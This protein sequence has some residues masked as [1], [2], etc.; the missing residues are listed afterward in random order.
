MLS[1][2]L[3]YLAHQ[4]AWSGSRIVRDTAWCCKL[5]Q[6]SGPG[7]QALTAINTIEDDGVSVAIWSELSMVTTSHHLLGPVI[8]LMKMWNFTVG[9]ATV[10]KLDKWD[11]CWNKCGSLVTVHELECFCLNILTT[12]WFPKPIIDHFW[13]VYFL[14]FGSLMLLLGRGYHVTYFSCL[15]SLKVLNGKPYS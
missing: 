11:G 8:N 5:R 9:P 4:V 13:L 15:L 2:I 12:L 1:T 6:R 14:P 7:R 10:S 3:C